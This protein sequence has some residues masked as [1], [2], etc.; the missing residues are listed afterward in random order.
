MS[1]GM[2]DAKT[3]AV[4][5]AGTGLGQEIARVVRREGGNVVLGARTASVLEDIAFGVDPSGDRV[6]WR[7][8]DVRDSEQCRALVTSAV[9]RFGGLDAV[10]ICAV[11]GDALVG[12]IAD[13]DLDEWRDLFEVNLF[14][15]MQVVSAAVP[16]METQGSIVFIGS[17]AAYF[18]NVI[19]AGYAASKAALVGVTHHLA[20]ELGPRGIRVNV[21][22]PG[23][24]WGPSLEKSL[25]AAT[26]G[27]GAALIEK[28]GR[29]LPL[30]T[31]AEDGDVAEAAAFLASARAKAITGQCLLVNA[32]EYTR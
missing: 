5:G 8:T 21:V 15:A 12:G 14:G 27:G 26:G 20:A 24:M 18:P 6:M 22:A 16:A 13:A 30:G 3:V 32:G 19:Q 17:Q 4:V 10:V 25:D 31:V 2:L 28:I 11:A 1:A 23:W 7:T 29:K 9:E